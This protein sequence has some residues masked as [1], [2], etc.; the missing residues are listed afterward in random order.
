MSDLELVLKNWSFPARSPERAQLTLRIPLYDHQRLLALKELY[1]NQSI[2]DM[3][4][5]ILEAA[6]NDIVLKMPISYYTEDD[7]KAI[8]RSDSYCG[9]EVGEA[10]GQRVWFNQI[11]KSIQDKHQE[12]LKESS[13]GS[14][15]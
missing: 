12:S 2:N 9:E 3:V 6:L 14:A 11:L 1:P 15:T 8:Q 10:Y 5:D 13:Q 4:V 7:L